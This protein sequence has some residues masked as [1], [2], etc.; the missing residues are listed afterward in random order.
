MP[1]LAVRCY[2]CGKVVGNKWDHYVKLLKEGKTETEALDALGLA[3]PCCRRMLL[4]HVDLSFK[5]L[6]FKAM[7]NQHNTSVAFG[8]GD[9]F[10]DGSDDDG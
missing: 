1:E 10:G 2:T 9:D 5:T 4:T 8:G 6:K 7:E 3:R